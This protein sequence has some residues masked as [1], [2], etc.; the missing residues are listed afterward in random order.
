MKQ[1]RAPTNPIW[2][3]HM[4]EVCASEIASGV[5]RPLVCL[6]NEIVFKMRQRF[7]HATVDLQLCRHGSPTY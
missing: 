3:L 4:S 6:L 5:G 1:N 2:T 7:G